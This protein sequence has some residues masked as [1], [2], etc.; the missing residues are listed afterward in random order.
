MFAD[1]LIAQNDLGLFLYAQFYGHHIY[2][3][4]KWFKFIEL[5]YV[6]YY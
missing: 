5:K 4:I 2:L 6:C 3:L 1:L